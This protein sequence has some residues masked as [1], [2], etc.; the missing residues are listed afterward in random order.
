[1]EVA[2]RLESV[3]EHRPVLREDQKTM[4]VAKA[5][6]LTASQQISL[7]LVRA[8]SQDL[9]QELAELGTVTRGSFRNIFRTAGGQRQEQP[10][11]L[12]KCETDVRF[13]IEAESDQEEEEEEDQAAAASP[14]IKNKFF[15]KKKSRKKP[16]S[17][18]SSKN[19]SNDSLMKH[20]SMKG[21]VRRSEDLITKL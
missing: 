1:M 4:M 19:Q 8:S 14:A 9:V 3:P 15:K 18:L 5:E 20:F 11:A 12:R 7:W 21:M 17:S 10:A 6:P 13:R 2:R 16:L